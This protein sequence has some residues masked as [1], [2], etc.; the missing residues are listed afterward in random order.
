VVAGILALTSA[1]SI[2]AVI[3][4]FTNGLFM[5][6]FSGAVAFLS[7]IITLVV[8]GYLDEREILRINN[9]ANNFLELRDRVWTFTY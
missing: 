8:T 9:G 4:E 2:T 5:K 1:A 3:A 7:G 6:I